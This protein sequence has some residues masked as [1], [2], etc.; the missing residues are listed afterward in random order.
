MRRIAYRE[1]MYH[2][3]MLSILLNNE[4]QPDVMVCAFPVSGKR[5]RINAPPVQV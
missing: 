3:N 4:P 5:V 1:N 2:V